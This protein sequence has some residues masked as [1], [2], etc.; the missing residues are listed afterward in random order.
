M[1]NKILKYK[2]FK[3]SVEFSKED[4]YYFGKILHTGRDLILYEG[5]TLKEL[6][7]DFKEAIDDYIEDFT[8]RRK[9][10]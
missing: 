2:M 10:Y 3:G 1:E 5:S 8:E 7:E 9:S 4:N 6:E